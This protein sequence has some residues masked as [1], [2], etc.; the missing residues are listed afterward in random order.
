MKKSSSKSKGKPSLEAGAKTSEN[1]EVAAQSKPSQKADTEKEETIEA[2]G[3]REAV[4]MQERELQ[5]SKAR[6]IEA[7][8]S[9]IEEFDE[10]EDRVV[11]GRHKYACPVCSKETEYRNLEEF[12]QHVDECLNKGAIS[13]I[14]KDNT[15][16]KISKW[17]G[18]LPV[19]KTKL[20]RY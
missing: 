4:T 6:E 20:V 19:T 8:E 13:S 10:D 14:M 2:G 1:S 3:S 5:D 12:N 9:E 18:V 15:S 17:L 11:S 7:R 16:R